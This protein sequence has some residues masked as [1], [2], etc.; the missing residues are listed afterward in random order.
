M[1]TNTTMGPMPKIP[2]RDASKEGIRD[3]CL[4]DLSPKEEEG[5]LLCRSTTSVYVS[6]L[7]FEVEEKKPLIGDCL[8]VLEEKLVC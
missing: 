1:D 7:A 2:W 3:R 8:E 6:L 5:T 4:L